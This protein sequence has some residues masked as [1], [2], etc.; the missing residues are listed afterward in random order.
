MRYYL[1]NAYYRVDH[2]T[3]ANIRAE[4]LAS[5]LDE[6]HDVEIVWV[7]CE[8]PVEGS[9]KFIPIFCKPRFLMVLEI[10]MKSWFWKGIVISDLLPYLGQNLTVK[11]FQLNHD[12]RFKNGYGRYSNFISNIAYKISYSS[13]KG[14]IAVSLYAKKELMRLGIEGKKIVVSNN[15][16]SK[17]LRQSTVRNIDIVFISVFEERKN[18]SEL[19]N[20]L[21]KNFKDKNVVFIGHDKGSR[22]SIVEMVKS[23]QNS[24][25]FL[26]SVS[27]EEK[28]EILSRCKNYVS[29]SLYEGFGMG[30]LEALNFGCRVISKD[31]EFAKLVFEDKI[32]YYRSELDLVSLIQKESINC[33][34]EIED[35]Y[36]SNIAK[37]LVD[38]TCSYSRK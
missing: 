38:D 3:G 11:W 29:P 30:L 24:Y 19:V 25:K 35:Y 13:C 23:S 1:I 10:F 4:K 36:W 33:N 32:F 20:I 22:D 34:V 21:E 37:K 2:F 7:G 6:L 26:E 28:E 8:K 27:E 18:H 5:A 31:V 12:L 16:V 17:N 9:F 14:I 15:G